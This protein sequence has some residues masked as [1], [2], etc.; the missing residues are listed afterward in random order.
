M[1]IEKR[2]RL[3]L[4]NYVGSVAIA[5]TACVANRFRLFLNQPLVST[6]AQL[7]L[8]SAKHHACEIPAYVFMSDHIHAIFRGASPASNGYKTMVAFKPQSGFWLSRHTQ[9]RWQK[10]FF[11]HIIRDESEI[12][13][14]AKYILNNP[15]C[16]GLV[17]DWRA[18]PFKGSTVH[19]FS[20]WDL[21]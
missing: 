16:A 9:S 11:G 1:V 3:P 4:H 7:L 10:D 21:A 6:F 13:K 14:H 8:E 12:S 19:N 18:Y 17:E 15:V 2:H 5:F 20:D